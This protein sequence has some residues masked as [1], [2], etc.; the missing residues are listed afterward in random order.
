MLFV[1]LLWVLSAIKCGDHTSVCTRVRFFL[2]SCF[3]ALVVFQDVLPKRDGTHFFFLVVDL[4]VGCWAIVCCRKHSLFVYMPHVRIYALPTTM[5]M[6]SGCNMIQGVFIFCFY[7][8]IITFFYKQFG[9]RNRIVWNKI[10]ILQ[11]IQWQE[12]V[13][14]ALIPW[15]RS[16]A[17]NS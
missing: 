11:K 12:T 8:N 15:I 5:M 17:H 2:L 6:I 3:D 16:T 4:F 7:W 10:W 14:Y 13:Y 1:L 9:F